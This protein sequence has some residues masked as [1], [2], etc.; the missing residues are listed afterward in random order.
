MLRNMANKRV[1]PLIL[2]WRDIESDLYVGKM[3]GYPLEHWVVPVPGYLEQFRHPGRLGVPITHVK[4][5]P[6]SDR[7]NGL[8]YIG[9]GW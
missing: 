8:T 5:L 3:N 2:L 7:W 1:V 4:R 6:M 9:R